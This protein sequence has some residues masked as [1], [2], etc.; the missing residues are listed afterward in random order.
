MKRFVV[1]TFLVLSLSAASMAANESCVD[2]LIPSGRLSGF[3]ELPAAIQNANI[4]Q[5]IRGNLEQ[6]NIAGL[7]K[8]TLQVPDRRE[9]WN[10]TAAAAS[11]SQ[12]AEAEI[13]GA[14]DFS[15]VSPEF[16]SDYWNLKPTPLSHA[17][18]RW[19]GNPFPTV[20]PRYEGG[21][22]VNH[23]QLWEPN[24]LSTRPLGVSPL[25]PAPF[26]GVL[27]SRSL[28]ISPFMIAPSL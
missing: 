3:T 11:Y 20:E 16:K 2:C 7:V 21:N 15:K 1:S 10:K 24:Y 9:D 18:P 17:M 25:T 4:S 19:D 14:F 6:N 12:G 22:W 23:S 28:G 27:P 13:P 26:A 8:P 5:Q